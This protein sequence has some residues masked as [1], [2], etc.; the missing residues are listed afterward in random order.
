MSPDLNQPHGPVGSSPA[1]QQIRA[2][3]GGAVHRPAERGCLEPGQAAVK[4]R[5][6]LLVA[7]AGMRLQEN[8]VL[9]DF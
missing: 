5:N 7:S 6:K 1:S 4:L 2:H 8:L 9:I 3:P